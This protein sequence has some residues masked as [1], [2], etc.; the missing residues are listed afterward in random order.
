MLGTGITLTSLAGPTTIAQASRTQSDVFDLVYQSFLVLGTIVG[1][2]VISYLLYNAYKYSADEET[3]EK[4]YDIDADA[5]E[6]DDGGKKVARPELG[7]L[8]SEADG[9]SGSKVFLSFA[10]S[11]VIVLGLVIFAYWN[12]LYVEGIAASPEGEGNLE[13]AGE[14]PTGEA[15]TQAGGEDNNALA[16]EVTGQQFFWEYTYPSGETFE[17]N[18]TGGEGLVVPEGRTVVMYVT[19]CA[20]G[21]C[22]GDVWHNWGTS[23]FRARADALPGQYTTTWFQPEQTGSFE[24]VC[25]ELCGGGHSAMRGEDIEVVSEDE[26]RDWCTEN[27]CMDEQVMNDWLERTGGDSE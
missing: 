20:P 27:S 18:Y 26:F 24:V 21:E 11:A 6:E 8:P 7:Q 16:I 4:R 17:S 9:S 3:P 25:Y 15:A 19:S 1:V 10:I 12:L 22:D 2:V 14:P 13:G 23:E 5:I